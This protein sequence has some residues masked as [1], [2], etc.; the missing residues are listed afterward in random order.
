M[1]NKIKSN[2]TSA[3]NCNIDP[4]IPH[5]PTVDKWPYMDVGYRAKMAESVS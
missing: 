2:A 5:Q 1:K 3:T 4:L